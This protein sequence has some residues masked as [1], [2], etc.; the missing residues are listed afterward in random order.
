MNF[1]D[2]LDARAKVCGSRVF[3]RLSCSPDTL[4]AELREKY[5]STGAALFAYL[6][7]EIDVCSGKYPGIVLSLLDFEQFGTSG[8][9]AFS[10]AASYARGLGLLVVSDDCRY[11]TAANV[12][13][14]VRA[15][16]SSPDGQDRSET[17]RIPLEEHG[18]NTDALSVSPL[19]DKAALD[20]LSASA[21][22]V[23]RQVFIGAGPLHT[24]SGKTLEVEG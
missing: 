11:V 3:K 14:L 9:L 24:L 19:S 16:F 22:T 6:K 23:G 17:H 1:F 2:K 13:A 10:A 20:A 5:R 8:V 7:A 18:Y 15:Y 21:A 4:P 12:Q